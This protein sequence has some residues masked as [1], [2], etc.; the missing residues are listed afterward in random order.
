MPKKP[1]KIYP[2]DIGLVMLLTGFAIGKSNPG[3]IAKLMRVWKGFSKDEGK[4]TAEDGFQTEERK[5]IEAVFDE[6]TRR[7]LFFK[8]KP[9]YQKLGKEIVFK[10]I[11]EGEL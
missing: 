11:A 8:M 1:I 9:E 6:K 7:E 4:G 5:N 2:S 10:L 3:T